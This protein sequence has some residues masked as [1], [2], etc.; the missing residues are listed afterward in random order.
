[1]TDAAEMPVASEIRVS[2]DV[3]VEDAGNVEA[4]ASEVVPRHDDASEEDGSDHV[5]S[6]LSLS[7]GSLSMAIWHS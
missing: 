1:M 6:Q 3:T 4:Q 7:I 5:V 2:E